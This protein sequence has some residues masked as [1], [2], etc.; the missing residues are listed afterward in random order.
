MVKWSRICQE[1]TKKCRMM[2]WCKRICKAIAKLHP[3]TSVSRPASWPALRWSCRPW[4]RK[5]LFVSHCDGGVGCG[6]A[7]HHGNAIW[8]KE[9]QELHLH[10]LYIICVCLKV[11]DTYPNMW[12]CSW[13]NEVLNNCSQ[14]RVPGWTW[15]SLFWDKLN[16]VLPV[17]H[18]VICC[19]LCW[20]MTAL[21]RNL[22]AHLEKLACQ[23]WSSWARGL[24]RL[25]PPVNTENVR[26]EKG[27][28]A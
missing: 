10:L 16:H 27:V 7:L 14:T 17:L 24:L 5:C 25:M 13:E 8:D 28:A 9:P 22:P 23:S 15:R 1:K 20:L 26:L 12:Q 2:A 3:G 4:Q 19:L 21:I 6:A 18:F 11:A